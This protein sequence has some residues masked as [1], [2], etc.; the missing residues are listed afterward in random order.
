M[1]SRSQQKGG[2]LLMVLWLAAA[3]SAIA[4]SL[5][6]SVRA[7][8]E[9]SS[10]AADGLRAT[11][12]ATGAVERGIQWMLWG[13]DYRLPTGGPRFW[14]PNQPRMTM[15]FPSGDAL[16]EMIPESAKLNIN[17][18]SA[19]QIERVVMAVSNDPAR[20]RDITAAILD[21]RGSAARPDFDQFYLSIRPTF[22]A[23]HA[24]FQEI[25]ELLLVRGMTPELFYG[26]YV[27]DPEG[28]LFATGGLRDCMSVWGSMGPFD[29]NGVSPAL[30]AAQGM[31]PGAVQAVMERR[32]VQPFRNLG[33]LAALGISAPGMKLGGNV[34]WTLRATARLRSPDGRPTEVIRTASATI[35][36]L[37]PKRTLMPLHVLRWYEDAWSQFAVT[38]A[39]GPAGVFRP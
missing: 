17:S 6:A 35:K 25:E 39:P 37:D 31:T 29:I 38:P 27:P 3:L 14:E 34:I 8:I 26:N 32:R 19:E 13:P 28:R 30:M 23:R 7:E 4:F 36:L 5:A 11:Y 2:A 21:W 24:S 9:H 10:T 1:T 22:R 33:E 18:A 16:I 20:S 12:L 15:S